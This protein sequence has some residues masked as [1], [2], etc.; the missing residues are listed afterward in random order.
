MN[1]LVI[2]DVLWR[3]DNGVGNS[4]SNIFANLPNVEIQNICCQEGR[5]DN[6][7][8]TR[9]FQISERR[10]LT[11]L[12]KPSIPSGTVENKNSDGSKR[13]QSAGLATRILKRSRMQILFWIR[14]LIWAVGKWK[15]K[16]LDTFIDDFNPDIIFAQLQ[17]KK[18]LNS[19]IRY[20]QQ[21]S[22]KKLVL[23]AWDDVYSLKQFSLSP[24]FWI[25]R[26][27]QRRSIRRL[28]KS[29]SFLYTI[30][31]EQREEYA[32]TLGIPTG[33]L[34]KGGPFTTEPAP[35]EINK[36][37]RVLYTGNLYSGRYDTLRS[38][39][40]LIDQKY[41][42]S[43]RLDIYSA[44]DLSRNQI[45][46]LNGC[47]SVYFH[48]TVSEREVSIL[49]DQADILLH[50]DPMSLK[51]SLIC[52]LS[53]STKLVDYFSKGKCIVAIGNKRCSSIKY[54]ER[55]NGAMTLDSISKLDEALCRLLDDPGAMKAYAHQ[56]W[57]C[58]CRNHQ[59]AS[60]QS[61]LMKRLGELASS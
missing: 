1:I 49:Q 12:V 7:V 26:F 17:D 19:L 4:Y 21:Y 10:L 38:I 3:T 13:I 37:I 56:A 55:N 23:Y 52:R 40:E 20:V 18:Y 61:E 51:G 34:F 53:F 25:D 57:E 50:I 27:L 11:N 43:I 14:D 41:N 24:L 44:T 30:S 32:R 60:V 29:A 59:I 54:L 58:G 2:T 5:S 39:A 42:E 28:I 36:P 48:G 35:S 22:G 6:T 47:R 31:E 9:C 46:R 45:N 15:T 16:A 33:V 8:S